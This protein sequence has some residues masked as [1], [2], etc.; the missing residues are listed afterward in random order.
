M[1][2]IEPATDGLRNRCSTTELHWH[3]R[4]LLS[5]EMVLSQVGFPA[6]NGFMNSG[7]SRRKF[8]VSSAVAASLSSSLFAAASTKYR[9]AVIGDTGHGDYGHGLDLIFNNR[10]NIE[11]VAVA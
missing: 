6:P 3:P 10:E 4:L 1:A 8:L 11:V 2:G 7:L 9:A 5:R